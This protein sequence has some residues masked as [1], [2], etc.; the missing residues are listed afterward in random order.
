MNTNT[1]E[2]PTITFRKTRDGEWAAFGPREHLLANIVTAADIVR[3]EEEAY[4][5]NGYRFPV[6]EIT[7]KNGETVHRAVRNV[8]RGFDVDGVEYA[9]GFLWEDRDRAAVLTRANLR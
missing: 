1:T 5:E 4:E 2:A 9:Y 7:K 8:T 6:I 3:D